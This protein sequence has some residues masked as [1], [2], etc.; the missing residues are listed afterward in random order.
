MSGLG[1]WD[2]GIWD[3]GDLRILDLLIWDFGLRGVGNLGFP[4]VGW[5]FDCGDLFC[6]VV[7]FVNDN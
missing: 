2:F 6:V 7:I 5:D 1:I 3:F 4:V